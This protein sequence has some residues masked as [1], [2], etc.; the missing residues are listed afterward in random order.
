MAVDL[1]SG[2]EAKQ[3]AILRIFPLNSDGH[4]NVME[5]PTSKH[6]RMPPVPPAN[7]SQKGPGDHSEI[8]SSEPLKH[9]DVNP[10]E[11]GQTANIRQNTTNKG[12][13]KGRRIK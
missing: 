2:F 1:P 10:A 13:F 9:A 8:P 12:F 7:H 3:P 5:T 4:G 6:G 11:Q